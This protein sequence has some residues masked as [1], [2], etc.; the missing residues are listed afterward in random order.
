MRVQTDFG[1][2]AKQISYQVRHG[3]SRSREQ[4]QQISYQV[5]R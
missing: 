3:W 1:Q 2:I 5:R 4:S